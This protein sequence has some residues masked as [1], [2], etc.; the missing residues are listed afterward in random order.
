VGLQTTNELNVRKI[1]RNE[2][3]IK[4][5]PVSKGTWTLTAQYGG[6]STKFP[7]LTTEELHD[8]MFEAFFW[9]EEQSA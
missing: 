8:V 9:L 7:N 3:G 5:F 6:K 1:Y 4:I 2:G